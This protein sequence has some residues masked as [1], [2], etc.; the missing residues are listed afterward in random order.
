MELQFISPA[1]ALRRCV[2]IYYRMRVDYRLIEDMERAD[3]GYLRFFLSGSGSIHYASGH[4]DE[5]SAVTLMGPATETGRYT[6]TGPLDCFGCV[7]LPEFWGGIVEVDAEACAN[8]CLEGTQFFGPD[9]AQHFEALSQM[10]TIDDMAKATD[11]FLMRHL[12]AIPDDQVA[13]ID[14]IGDWLSCFPIPPTERLYEAIPDKSSR[15][16]LRLANRHYGAAPKML[17]RKFR[18]LR[19]ASRLV[20]TRGAIPEVLI[21]EYSDRAHLSREIKHFT[22]LTPRQLQI[23]SN[24]I[25]RVTLHPDNFRAQSPWM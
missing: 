24:P 13:V 19:T 18:A 8:R 1:P 12:N 22:G 11:A 5:G 23:N 3:V 20:G 6:L 15:Q 21:D 14:K 7:L 10:E 16:V 4:Q 9:A 25:V 2:S 17:A